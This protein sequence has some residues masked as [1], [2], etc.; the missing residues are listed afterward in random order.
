MAA[1]VMTRYSTKPAAAGT[2]TH[3]TRVNAPPRLQL[4]NGAASR[5][6]LHAFSSSARSYDGDYGRDRSHT[7]TGGGAERRRPEK[8]VV[9]GKGGKERGMEV[10][11]ER[12]SRLVLNGE[13]VESQLS[14]ETEESICQVFSFDTKAANFEESMSQV[15]PIRCSFIVRELIETERAYVQ[16]LGE[17]IKV[18]AIRA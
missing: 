11:R 17:I 6:S 9:I 4:S 1:A 14:P 12:S 8:M 7:H 10:G 5:D 2:V 18:L 3:K 15:W 13:L 16:A